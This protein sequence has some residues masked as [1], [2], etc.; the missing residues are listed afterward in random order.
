MGTFFDIGPARKATSRK[1]SYPLGRALLPTTLNNTTV[2]AARTK[3]PRNNVTA[4]L[5]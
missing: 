2:R 3:A 1:V 5:R 4:Q